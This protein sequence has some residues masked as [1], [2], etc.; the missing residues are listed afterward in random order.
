ME[1]PS[2]TKVHGDT[3]NNRSYDPRGRINQFAP[4]YKEDDCREHLDHVLRCRFCYE[5]LRK[6]LKLDDTTN[7]SNSLNSPF[8]SGNVNNLLNIA[9]IAMG[10]IFVLYMVDTILSRKRG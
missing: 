8:Y 2:I 3:Y 10:G 7:S 4:Q 9:L 1:H 5:H 6:K